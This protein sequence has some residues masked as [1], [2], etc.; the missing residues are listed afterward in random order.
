MVSHLEFTQAEVHVSKS[1][2]KELKLSESEQEYKNMI[3][4]YNSRIISMSWSD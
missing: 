1:E 2:V 4:N 3:I